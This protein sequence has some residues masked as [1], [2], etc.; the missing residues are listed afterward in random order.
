MKFFKFLFTMTLLLG[1]AGLFIQG[2]KPGLLRGIFTRQPKYRVVNV[3]R[4]KAITA[5]KDPVMRTGNLPVPTKKYRVVTPKKTTATRKKK[6]GGLLPP[7]Y[8]QKWGEGDIFKVLPV[9]YRDVKNILTMDWYAVEDLVAFV[10]SRTT[11]PS[12]YLMC[13][14]SEESSMFQ[15]IGEPGKGLADAHVNRDGV[16]SYA[17]DDHFGYNASETKSSQSA[18]GGYGSAS[19]GAQILPSNHITLGGWKLVH[20]EIFSNCHKSYTKKDLVYIQN[21]LN[22]YFEREVVAVDGMPGPKTK[23]WLVQYF[24]KTIKKQHMP[25]P[26]DLAKFVEDEGFVKTMLTVQAGFSLTYHR[27][28]DDIAKVMGTPGPHDPRDPVVSLIAGALIMK[29]NG[30]TNR[31]KYATGAYFA[32]PKNAFGDRGKGYTERFYS[33]FV[34]AQARMRAYYK[35][36]GW[37]TEAG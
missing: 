14:L 36:Y 5:I 17:L 32:G 3:K 31:P 9:Q 28:N 15:N 35:A 19:G 27:E 12:E 29:E 33:Y 6:D 30:I 26:K 22:Q 21:T 2:V 8:P 10:A 1:A 25:K 7:P 37:K 13:L 34:W 4:G 20:K 23:K 24:R 16:A 18:G 11:V